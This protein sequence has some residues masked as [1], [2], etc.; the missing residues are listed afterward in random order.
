MQSSRIDKKNLRILIPSYVIAA[1]LLAYYL[2]VLCL[3]MHPQVTKEYRMF[4]ID[5]ALKYRVREGA[6]NVKPSVKLY[7]DGKDDSDT[8]FYGVGQGFAFEYTGHA[9]ENTGCCYTT[10]GHNYLYFDGVGEGRHT[11]RLHVKE[12]SC[13]G[14]E[15]YVNGIGAGSFD[16]ASGSEVM[17]DII[18]EMT[19][20]PKGEDEVDVVVDIVPASDEPISID[21]LT[22]D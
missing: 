20:D 3:G 10:A 1:V 2:Y 21:H 17:V 9:M 19:A 12:T 5:H 4:Y 11:L 8:T 7:L 6:L 14:A 15:I 13:P 22:F 16:L 18:P